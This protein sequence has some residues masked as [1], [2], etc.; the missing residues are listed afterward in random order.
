MSRA[1][2][3]YKRCK[4]RDADGKDIGARCPKLKRAD[5]SWNPKHGTWYF[6]LELPP[7][8]GGKRRPRMRRGGF[9]TREA[10]ETARETA[11]D[12]L[13]KG[14]DP[15]ERVKLDAYLTR[16]LANRPDLKPS[17]RHGY[18][19][20]VRTYLVPLLGHIYLSQLT[21]DDIT[22]AFATIRHWN[23]E[24]AAGRP[25]RKFQ[26]RVG[27]AAMQRIRATLRVA[28]NDAY[29][30]GRI[31]A[32]PADRVRMESEER[33]K[34]VVWTAERVKAFWSAYRARADAE[35]AAGRT[36]RTFYIWRDMRLRP[37]PVMV[38]SMADAGRFLDHA[39]SCRLSAMFEVA[40]DTGM[41]RG[42]VCG[43]RWVDVDLEALEVAVT[44]QRVQ[45]AWKVTE[46]APKSEAGRRVVH[47]TAAT[48][49]AL[50]ALRKRQMEDRLA[51][52]E[53][54]TET[55]LVFT[56]EDG[57]ALHPAS[58]TDLFERQA[59]AA[60]LPP[61]RFHDLRH[62]HGTIGDAARVGVKVMSERLGHSTTKLTEDTYTSVYPEIGRA[63]AEKIAAM[64]PREASW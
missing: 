28:L 20:N 1:D 24:L 7:G 39:R 58:V 54:W 34:P 35:K 50:R 55:G 27:P 22:A 3:V 5:N 18:E 36:P 14:A 60:G 9:A 23:D 38:W 31:P 48:G 25:V 49:R 17:T 6:A 26:R 61:I 29:K 16:W 59:M 51:W 56:H 40:V 4:C 12:A 19:V 43:L 42:E 52:G 33:R 47:F 62:I 44:V 41:R 63:A 30:S 8:P 21:A 37:A 15:S 13:R 53:A 11:K 2:P 57:R 64:I 10:A 45:V 32:N 46:G